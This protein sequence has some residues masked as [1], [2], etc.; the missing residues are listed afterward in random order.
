MLEKISE[1]RADDYGGQWTFQKLEILEQYLDAYTTALK[2]T[3]FKLVYIDAFA[4][5]GYINPDGDKQDADDFIAG[6]ATRAITIENRPFDKLIFIEK[7]PSRFSKLQNLREKYSEREITV[8][9]S[10]A[11]ICLQDLQ[12]DWQKWRGVL[13]LDPFATEVEWS[14]IEKIA[15][16]EALDTWLLFPV[17]AI[18]RILPLSREPDEIDSRWVDRLNSIFGNE[19]WRHL[20][21]QNPQEDMFNHSGYIRTT[22]VN[23]LLSIYKENLARLFGTRLMPKSK[24]LK[25]GKG[26]PLFEFIFCAGHQRGAPIAKEI[27]G[28][29]IDSSG[30]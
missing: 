27:A 29:I 4:G 17:S 8:K 24:T 16:F 2:N 15:H 20:Y 6:S 28:Y 26:S 18:A 11:N 19:S 9:Q 22:G 13:F 21:Q 3:P 14:T 25:T 7:S 12:I 5:T 30:F 1:P 10:D 23:G